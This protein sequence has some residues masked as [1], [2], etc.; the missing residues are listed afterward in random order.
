M[1]TPKISVIVPV[2]NAERFLRECLDS[3]V[4]Q[5]YVAKEVLLIDD[6]STD[7][8]GSICDEYAQRY[9]FIR[10]IHKK[11]GGPSAARNTGI[12]EASGEWVIFLDSDDLWADSH[13]LS[14]LYR[15]VSLFN[16]DIVRFE[17][18]SVNEDLQPI[19]QRISNKS[20]IEGH[21]IDN[22]NLVRY[23]IAGEWFTVLFLM[24]RCLIANIRFNEN[25]NFLEDC[26][27]Y[28][29]LFATRT[30][31]CGYLNEKMYLYRKGIPSISASCNV[32]KLKS[33][34]ALCDVF[35]DA[36]LKIE[37][38]RLRQLYVYYS[39][40]MYYWTLQTLAASPYYERRTSIIDEL[41]LNTLHQ[42]ILA[43]LRDAKVDKKY[44]MFILPDPKRG[45]RILHFK[46]KLMSFLS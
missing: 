18:Q 41:Q 22:Y 16:L 24:R 26:D 31:R 44:K 4:S 46:D 40:M 30:M 37:D 33:S 2:Y 34:F 1:N 25:I 29:S 23:G 38:E 42:R 5:D 39:V 9:S 14:K 36:S 45:V 8:S 7:S 17:Y 11:N 28:S 12:E 35:Y 21:V 27:F 6:G 20:I 3:V 13:C 32:D 15:Y 10:V 19:G 43:R